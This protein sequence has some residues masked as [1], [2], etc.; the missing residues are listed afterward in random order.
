MHPGIC[1]AAVLVMTG[2]RVVSAQTSTAD[3]VAA[4]AR[5]DYQRAAEILKPAA[6]SNRVNDTAAQFFMATMY[7]NGQG[8]ALDPLRACALYQRAAANSDNPLGMEALQLL[9]PSLLS[10]DAGWIEDCQILTEV[11]F[12]HGFEPVTFT[13]GPRHST[14]W[15]IKGATVTYGE[16]SKRFPMRLAT[17]GS[18]FL[19]LQLTELATGPARSTIR[20]FVEVFLWRPSADTSSWNLAWDAFEITQD[21]VIGVASVEDVT[22][23]AADSPPSAPAFDA[24]AYAA[25]RVT[26][27]GEAEWAVLQGPHAQAELIQSEAERQELRSRKLARDAA[28]KQVDW[29]REFDEHRPPS[30]AYAAAEGCG[31]IFVY[32]WS[33]ERAET[34]TVRADRDLIALS[35]TPAAIEIERQAAGLFVEIHVYARAKRSFPFCTDVG[36]PPDPGP[37]GRDETWHAVSGTLTIQLSPPGVRARSPREYRAMISLTGAVFVN[38]SGTRVRQTQPIAL[39]AVVGGWGG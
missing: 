24:R 1:L 28:D 38:Q 33:G 6:E 26:D 27:E 36:S 37:Y 32:G 21:A 14:A 35:T 19:P 2:G 7:E 34:I 16:Q 18:V 20:H 13:L 30:M 9:R 10:H 31:G 29:A 22:R 39:T 15:D 11:G 12:N 4:L 5:G 25:L 3:G 17:R 8:V 23:V